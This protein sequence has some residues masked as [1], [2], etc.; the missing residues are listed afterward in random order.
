VE[1]RK[2]VVPVAGQGTRL[3]PATKTQP[4][5]MLP[6]GRKPVIQYVLEE[7]GEQKIRQVLLVT[8]AKKRAIEDHFD[9]DPRLMADIDMPTQG[10]SLFYTRQM[11]PPGAGKPRGLG[12]AI[13]HSRGFV[14]GE[15]F[16]VALGDTIIHADGEMTLIK[17]LIDAHQ[18]T[19]ASATI[20]VWE[21]EL[22]MTRWYGIIDP[23]GQTGDVITIKDIVEKP[24]P[25]DAPS[26]LSV[27]ARYVFDPVI[28]DALDRTLPGHGGEIQLTDAIR[29]L[30]RLDHKVTCVKLRP[31]ETRYDIGNYETYFKA[32]LDFALRDPDHGDKML[33]YMRRKVGDK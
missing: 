26:L 2:A 23:D 18:S 21:V 8:G 14:G 33:E 6:V 19:E 15:P 28:Y 25:Q 7:L 1:I 11:V 17:R 12:D 3:L 5:E 10:V 16:V 31:D 9:T 20:A 32:F 29:N 30:I 4:K 22:E 24:R 13:L 27:A